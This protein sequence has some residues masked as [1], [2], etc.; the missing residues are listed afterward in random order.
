M[1]TAKDSIQ[2]K[3]EGY[4]NGA[5][6]YL[7]K[8]FSAKLLKSRIR[9]LLE[10]RKQLA[11]QIVANVPIPAIDAENQVNVASHPQL[12]KLDETFLSKLTSLVEDNLDEE[13]IDVTFMTDRMNMSYSSFSPNEFVRKIKLKNSVRLIL[14]G[15]YNISEA[16]S[17]TGFNN[18][19]HFRDCFKEE[20]GMSPS[21]Y[22]KQH[23][24]GSQSI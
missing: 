8:P 22:L 14:T 5:D 13:K 7:T 15:E 18:M 3:E 21:E 12:S 23:R 4:D 6:S 20:F 24:S 9:N 19:A 11:K 10:T 1:L 16:A 17:M 2:D